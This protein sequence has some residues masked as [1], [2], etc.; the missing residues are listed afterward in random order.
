MA[1]N[2]HI[3]EKGAETSYIR[4]STIFIN[5]QKKANEAFIANVAGNEKLAKIKKLLGKK[6]ITIIKSQKKFF[7]L[8]NKYENPQKLGVDRLLA[9]LGLVDN[10]H[11]K[12]Q[13]SITKT[14][15]FG[16]IIVS[17][18]SAI[19]I[20][21]WVIKTNKKANQYSYNGGQIIPGITLMAKSLNQGTANLPE[22]KFSSVL[23]KLKKKSYKQIFAQDTK[24]SIALGILN[25]LSASIEKISEKTNNSRI[26]ISTIYLTGGDAT[27]LAKFINPK[28]IKTLVIDNL[29]LKG[30]HKIAQN[31][32]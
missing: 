16:T 31:K 11:L 26:P 22:I 10:K 25:S 20:D 8:K 18:G 29:V 9:M 1:Q 17:C 24:T 6:K 27:L 21:Y 32:A 4:P 7:G 14:N 23:K 5:A 19:A 30:I 2:S 15:K 28:N 13:I 3:I 12:K